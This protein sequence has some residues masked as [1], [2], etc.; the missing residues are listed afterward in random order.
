MTQ[1][2]LIELSGV[3][4]STVLRYEA[5]KPTDQPRPEPE[6]VRRVFQ[7]LGIPFVESVIALGYLTREEAGLTP[8]PPRIFD[9]TVEEV[10]EILQDPDVP[11]AQKTEWVHYLRFRTGR[12]GS[13]TRRRA[14]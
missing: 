7:A 6:L 11:D 4:R 13:T 1:D 8:E 12:S 14:V 2:E 3:P 9:A 5:Y 10:I